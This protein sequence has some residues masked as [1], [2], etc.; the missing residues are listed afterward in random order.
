MAYVGLRLDL[1]RRRLSLLS[2][3]ALASA[4][5]GPLFVMIIRLRH[6]SDLEPGRC[7]L[8]SAPNRAAEYVL[9]A[10]GRGAFRTE[11]VADRP[12]ARPNCRRRAASVLSRRTARRNQN[13]V[14][15][16]T[17]KWQLPRIFGLGRVPSFLESLLHKSVKGP[18]TALAFE[19]EI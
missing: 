9:T 3:A 8:A 5:P 14:F 16:H 2:I 17:I 18:E 15:T 13:G 11:V 6:P 7:Y 19:Y 10:K 12:L 1:A 4:L